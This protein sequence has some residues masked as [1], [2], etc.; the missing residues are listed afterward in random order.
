MRSMNLL[1]TGA[2]GFIGSHFALR[3]IERQPDDTVVVLDK[4]TYAGHKEYLDPV[5]KRV[6]FIQG[7]IADVELLEQLVQRYGIEGIVNF[8]AETHVDRSIKNAVPFLHSNVL[9]VQALIEICRL[10]PTILLYHISTDEVYGEVKDGQKPHRIEDPLVPSS[11]YAASK[12]AG[13]LLL[14]AAVRT[15]GIRVRI[16]RCTNNF[17]PH[18]AD[19]KFIPTVIRHALKGEPVPLYAQGKNRRDW[20]YVSDHCDAV[21]LVLAAKDLDGSCVNISADDGRENIAVAKEILKLLRKPESLL[22]FVPDRPGHDWSYALDSSAIRKMGWKPQ[23]SFQD[24]LERTV[25]W[26]RKKWGV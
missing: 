15:Y 18:Q 26:Y 6:R 7:D 20:L 10:H 24:G 23:I 1:V 9:G 8:A 22:T 25:A 16:S 14:H 21:E 3:H 13:D 19:E 12:A 11:P 4:L 2:A 17:G 5:I